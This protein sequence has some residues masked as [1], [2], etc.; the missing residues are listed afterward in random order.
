MKFSKNTNIKP[1]KKNKGNKKQESPKKVFKKQKLPSGLNSDIKKKEHTKSKDSSNRPS[2][3][4]ENN[5]SNLDK[6]SKN[7]EN[8]QAIKDDKKYVKQYSN[9]GD[10]Y[11]WSPE[12]ES[13]IKKWYNEFTE[14]PTD[15]PLSNEF[16]LQSLRNE[17]EEVLKK[18]T[19]F[20]KKKHNK[21]GQSEN[22]WIRTML[23]K[24]TA[25]D[26]VAANVVMIQESPVYNLAAITSMVNMVKV[27]K[28][29]EGILVL[30]TLT[31][32][33]VSDLLKHEECLKTFDQHPLSLLNEITSGN[34]IARRNR[35]AHWMFEDH[36]KKLYLQFITSIDVVGKDTI[37][38][39]REK[40]V[41]AMFK[42]LVGNVEQRTLLLRTLVNKLGD[43]SQKVASKVIYSL[44]QLLR[45]K[46]DMKQEVL[47]EIEKLLFRPNVGSKAQYYAICFL[48]QYHF[49]DKDVQI[50]QN[51]ITV[52][53]SFF[54]ASIKKG[55]VDTRMLAALLMGVNRA[56]P[57]AK[58]QPNQLSEHVDTMF[59]LVHIASFNISI[60]C[61]CL[62]FQI[63]GH[64]QN[65]FYCALYKK[66]L[67]P[68][69][70]GS[71]HQAMFLNLLFKA[72]NSDEDLGRVRVFIKRLLQ[73]CCYLPVP[74]VCGLLYTISHLL[75]KRPSLCA[76]I[77]YKGDPIY[78]GDDESDGDE[79][80][81]DVSI[82]NQEENSIIG[83]KEEEVKKE[84]FALK[85]GWHH[86]T[87]IKH[88]GRNK[89]S[90]YDPTARNP[91][92]ANGE[93][94]SYSELT[95]LSNHFHPTVS[96]FATK[97]LNKQTISYTGDPLSD[98][99]LIRFLERFVFKNPKQLAPSVGETGPD[100]TLAQKKYYTPSGAKALPVDSSKYL[101][102]AE[103]KVPVD[104]IFLYRYLKQ[105]NSKTEF[106]KKEKDSDSESIAS[107]DFEDMLK[108]MVGYSKKNL[109]FADDVADNLKKKTNNNKLLNSNEEDS[110]GDEAED[111][112]TD[113]EENETDLEDLE[114]EDD[115]HNEAIDFD[116]E[117][118]VSF[119]GDIDFDNLDEEIAKS[120]KTTKKRKMEIKKSKNQ[121]DIF[122]LFAP[123][124]QFSEMLEEAGTSG[125]KSGTSNALLNKDKAAKKQLD[126]ETTRNQWTSKKRKLNQKKNN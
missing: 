22:S 54:K 46:P 88:P 20:Y 4:N 17:A 122:S 11:K 25:S 32:L 29:K 56:Y 61:L 55:E 92:F 83:S 84:N 116:G 74:L 90:G 114:D 47:N 35:L 94:A 39:N 120:K 14:E 43:P 119:D 58:L 44:T 66:L 91:A 37:E 23:N 50:A 1:Y 105:R 109:D 18:E 72:L 67:D 59:K 30:E 97:V 110:E 100:P 42:L 3:K 85:P 57:F 38:S 28:K 106:S 33:F 98:F 45:V 70:A 115:D 40:A 121:N 123:A 62:L 27:A 7:I 80:Y 113:L 78:T 82:Q 93:N 108:G 87:N 31:E 86:N 71:A 10:E 104:E 96:L 26:K 101:S 49:E 69:L 107:E 126:W 24:G 118:A 36:L 79:F 9:G 64:S 34:G 19:E 125:D 53:F 111:E 95:N 6:I 99:T 60:Q 102:Q 12:L 2:I 16:E 65:R 112:E 75:S 68:H 77:T 81:K 117:D 21:G 51:I 73:I 63:V 52:Y 48:S 103:S 8:K 5:S 89:N 41:T 124:E 76:T 13:D 15:F